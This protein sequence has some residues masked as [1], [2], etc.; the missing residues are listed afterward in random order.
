MEIGKALREIEQI[1]KKLAAVNHASGI[2]LY[3]GLTAAPRGSAPGRSD[4]LAWLA[5]EEHT[6]FANQHVG[7]LLGLLSEN[8]NALSSSDAKKVL[9]LKERYDKIVNIPVREYT[10][11]FVLTNESEDVWRKCKEKNDYATFGPYIDRIV[12][13]KKRFA[14]YY[15]DKKNPYDVWLNEFERGSSM[16]VFD[17][18]FSVVKSELIPLIKEIAGRPTPDVSFLHGDFPV[19]LQREFSADLMN[20]LG[21]DTNRCV[22][23]ETEHPF[24][25]CLNYYDC[26]ITTHYHQNNLLASMYSVLHEGGHAIYE[27]N[28]GKALY[29][30]ILS[31]A[32]MGIHESQSRFFENIIGRSKPF[33][34]YI[35]PVLKKYFKDFV[36]VNPDM[37][38]HAVNLSKPSLIRIEA[39]ELTYSMHII[40]RYEIERMLFSGEVT[41]KDLPG[42]WNSLYKEYLGVDVPNDSSGVL[43]DTHWGSGLFGY[44]PS[45]SIGSAY[46]A[47]ILFHMKK[48]LDIDGLV[49]DGEIRPA[50]DWLS[51]RIYRFGALKTPSELIESSCGELFN[52]KY[53]I[54]Y[55]QAK[56]CEL[57]KI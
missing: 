27:M 2:L 16:A 29:G 21:I 14:S 38:Y 56:Y 46:S 43:Q 9:L 25:E 49:A 28:M 35:L 36:N 53:Y 47:Q 15:D 54:N 4:T 57:Y 12:A 22:I 20:F 52:P 32:S 26:R 8:I 51:D 23:G 37:F 17:D 31:K 42:I 33:C 19:N 5:E 39:D 3:D 13:V 6:L 55:L 50:V 44:F 11:Y 1:E 40:I 30:T 45:Y 18:Y 7:E 24:T 48:S 10:E 41:Q 34:E